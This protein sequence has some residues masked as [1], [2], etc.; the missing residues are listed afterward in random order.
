M[1]LAYLSALNAKEVTDDGRDSKG[2]TSLENVLNKMSLDETR[3][4]QA[5]NGSDDCAIMDEKLLHSSL[6]SGNTE[7]LQ[8]NL[9]KPDL[10]SFLIQRACKSLTLANYLY[11]YLIIECEDTET[12][13]KQDVTIFT[14]IFTLFNIYFCFS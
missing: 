11:W 3:T 14:L 9:Q 13:A 8:G 1:L 7:T 10:A 4:S 2:S 5:D 12:I 6:E